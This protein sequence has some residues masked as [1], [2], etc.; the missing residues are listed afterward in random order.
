ML[1]EIDCVSWGMVGDRLCN[2][3]NDRDGLCSTTYGGV[4]IATAVCSENSTEKVDGVHCNPMYNLIS[5][6]ALGKNM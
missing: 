2:I 3:I 1:L 6:Q 5:G 4:V